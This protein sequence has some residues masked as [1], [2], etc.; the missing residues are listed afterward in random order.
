[1][2]HLLHFVLL[3]GLVAYVVAFYATRMPNFPATDDANLPLDRMAAIVVVARYPSRWLFSYWFGNPAQFALADRL[4]VLLTAGLIVAWAAVLGWLLMVLLRW[5]C[6]S[7]VS[8]APNGATAAPVKAG[9]TLAP[10]GDWTPSPQLTGLEA[11]IFALAMG[12]GAPEHVDA[13]VGSCRP[14]GSSMDVHRP[15]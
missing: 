14:V 5:L 2:R 6:S 9:K 7:G 10:P 3:I 12:L 4:P 8:P 13:A 11:G 1:M 15:G